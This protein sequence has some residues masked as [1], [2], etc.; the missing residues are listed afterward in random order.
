M[1]GEP[2]PVNELKA[3]FDRAARRIRRAAER[4]VADGAA[5]LSD[6]VRNNAPVETGALRDSVHVARGSHSRGRVEDFVVIEGGHGD[7]P[8][9]LHVEFGTEDE[10]PDPFIRRSVSQMKKRVKSTIVESILGRI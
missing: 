9:A 3:D 4:G 8:V 7:E 10:S 6:R 1:H 5:A 2:D